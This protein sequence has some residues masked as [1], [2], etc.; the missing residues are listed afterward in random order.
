MTGSLAARKEP[1]NSG[2]GVLLDSTGKEN[3]LSPGRLDLP[4]G[5]PLSRYASD[6]ALSRRTSPKAL[7]DVANAQ[8]QITI[9]AE[10][11]AQYEQKILQGQRQRRGRFSNTSTP[12]VSRHA[13]V[14]SSEHPTPRE[15]QPLHRGT[16]EGGS[17]S[18]GQ[19]HGSHT[20][21][22]LLAPH[23]AGPDQ[24][25]AVEHH[26]PERGPSSESPRQAQGTAAERLDVTEDDA[27]TSAAAAI[28]FDAS[29][30][31]HRT[32]LDCGGKY[33]Q[34]HSATAVPLNA[35][36]NSGGDAA[37]A[38]GPTVNV[39]MEQSW[40]SGADRLQ[41]AAE[42]S[43]HSDAE[44]LPVSTCASALPGF[45]PEPRLRPCR[46]APSAAGASPY[47]GESACIATTRSRS[48]TQPE[49]PPAD[50]AAAP[51]M[52]QSAEASPVSSNNFEPIAGI[53]RSPSTAGHGERTGI[54]DA[55]DNCI[56]ID[57]SSGRSAVNATPCSSSTAAAT[58]VPGSAT[59]AAP[60][61]GGEAMPGSSG[62]AEVDWAAAPGS[63]P[64]LVAERAGAR[65]Q[66]DR[67]GQLIAESAHEPEWVAA[68]RRVVSLAVNT[69]LSQSPAM[70]RTS[71]PDGRQS[72]NAATPSSSGHDPRSL[73]QAPSPFSEGPM[74]GGAATG[75]R[76]GSS[77]GRN[78]DTAFESALTDCR[79]KRL[80]ADESPH[81][82]GS[83]VRAAAAV[84]RAAERATLD[85]NDYS[86]ACISAEAASALS[87][88]AI[89]L[90]NG[91]M[92]HSRV[93]LQA[94][95][96][97]VVHQL[98][99]CLASMTEQQRPLLHAINTLQQGTKVPRKDLAGAAEKLQ[100][101][102][103]LRRWS[104]IAQSENI[105]RLL[106][107][108][109]ELQAAAQARAEEVHLSAPAWLNFLSGTG[110]RSANAA[111]RLGHC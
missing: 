12:D 75:W 67:G 50:A 102:E 92:A 57:K 107:I 39:S 97:D 68:F 54:V 85:R 56:D 36:L 58:G 17:G 65:Q 78:L 98:R 71:L 20:A 40:A 52:M 83:V 110:G 103:R 3:L 9:V 46:G 47:V 27:D 99:F 61:S 37:S 53:P 62:A 63:G 2:S 93:E 30:R 22:N 100:E 70:R 109:A 59:A 80:R 55:P 64:G 76:T 101:A 13:S 89:A 106:G 35:Q 44:V 38:S 73:G 31:H 74:E 23:K 95:L 108:V 91:I 105:A 111:G 15:H 79:R 72:D 25:K 66:N 32:D 10:A 77:G 82:S 69:P 96:N 86:G 49:M 19:E 43:A 60:S 34:A 41:Q 88:G 42:S 4:N 87:P 104:E 26:S 6:A 90:V 14:C 33:D 11:V 18:S 24:A 16:A 21:D 94:Q 7:P 48:S 8:G 1:E 51:L 29:G 5:T 81:S 28:I 45:E 84:Q